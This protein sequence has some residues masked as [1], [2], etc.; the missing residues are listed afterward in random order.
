MPVESRVCASRKWGGQLEP[1]R[2]R[3]VPLF[4][5]LSDDELARCAGLMEERELLAG[6]PIIREGDFSYRFFVVLDGEVDVQREFKHVAYVGPGGFVGEMGVTT[7]ARR[8]A[9]V[10]AHSRCTL[11][12]MMTW[13]FQAMTEEFP[14][15]A[16]RIEDEIA[17]RTEA[18]PDVGS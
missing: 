17:R 4:D 18:P 3:S 12:L 8:N 11:A 14:V 16:S 13:D 7:G 1:E 6:T 2:L 5:G 9:R 15:I 10:W